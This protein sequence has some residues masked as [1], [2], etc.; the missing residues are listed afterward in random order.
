MGV[1]RGDYAVPAIRCGQALLMTH[2]LSEVRRDA[3][4]N[5]AWL[6]AE[7]FQKTECDLNKLTDSEFSKPVTHLARLYAHRI[8]HLFH[9][10]KD[11]MQI[12]DF[13][14]ARAVRG[15]I[16]AAWKSVLKI[17]RSPEV[18]FQYDGPISPSERFALKAKYVLGIEGEMPFSESI[19]EGHH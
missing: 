3:L 4:Q 7:D 11:L 14:C 1:E 15:L 10:S 12:M 2:W 9:E 17:R 8:E 19:H 18:L 5:T 13:D 16:G 6:A